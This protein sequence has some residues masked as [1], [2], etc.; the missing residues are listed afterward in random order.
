MAEVTDPP[1]SRAFAGFWFALSVTMLG[2]FLMGLV[3]LPRLGFEY[4]EVMFVPLIFHPEKSLFAARIWHHFVPLMQM[5]Y[6]GAL[7]IWLYWP[8]I[9]L[10]HPGVYSV[11]LRPAVIAL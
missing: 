6:I 10:W 7:K 5:S 11:R 9:R 2:F 3:F 8:L 4:D 1:K